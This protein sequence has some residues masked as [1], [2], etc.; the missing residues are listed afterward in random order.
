MLARFIVNN[1]E[2]NTN[3]KNCIYNLGVCLTIKLARYLAMLLYSNHHKDFKEQIKDCIY[4]WPKPKI[5]G[6]SANGV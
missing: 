4:F 1:T 2:Y 6:W 5:A 3:T